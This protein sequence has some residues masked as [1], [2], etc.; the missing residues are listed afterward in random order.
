MINCSLFD[1]R[2]VVKAPLLLKKNEGKW[3]CIVRWEETMS[4]QFDSVGYEKVLHPTRRFNHIRD[5]AFGL[6]SYITTCR[7]H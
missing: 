6:F 2:C 7:S 5:L 4:V 1:H 3:W